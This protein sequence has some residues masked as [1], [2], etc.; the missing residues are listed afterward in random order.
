M[1]EQEVEV[2]EVERPVSLLAGKVLG[3]VPIM[4]IAVIR[5]NSEW[6]CYVWTIH[7][8]ILAYLRDYVYNLSCRVYFNYVKGYTDNLSAKLS[9]SQTVWIADSDA[10]S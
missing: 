3:S 2:A 8:H 1:G 10:R 6:L 7:K 9:E 5:N 4:K